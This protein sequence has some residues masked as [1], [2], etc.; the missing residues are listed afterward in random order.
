MRLATRVDRFGK[1]TQLVDIKAIMAPLNR[2]L[3]ITG[4]PFIGARFV[5]W[6]VGRWAMMEMVWKTPVDTGEA[7]AGWSISP[8]L[9]STGKGYGRVGF[10]ITNPVGYVIFLE[11]GH[12]D[13]A[14]QGM[15]RVTMFQARTE[16]KNLM[17]ELIV[18]WQQQQYRLRGFKWNAE[19][20]AGE[21]LDPESIERA[22]PS[23]MWRQLM[24]KLSVRLPLDKPISQLNAEAYLAMRIDD[25]KDWHTVSNFKEKTH[26]FESSVVRFT[27]AKFEEE[28]F[29]LD[30]GH[31]ERVGRVTMYT[32][33][34]VEHVR[35]TASPKTGFEPL[36]A[37]AAELERIWGGKK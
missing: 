32:E 17:D 3:A 33:S 14:P 35:G 10:R 23:L 20:E 24:G 15:S 31:P 2:L 12:S 16:L 19:I 36:A 6:H 22:L 18:F 34:Q 21:A 26:V 29:N 30:A 28:G 7:A 25:P 37:Q 27:R 9:R 8:Q 13:K 5:V 1:K 4:I 11:H